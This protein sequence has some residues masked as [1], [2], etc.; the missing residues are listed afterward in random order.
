M[1]LQFVLQRQQSH[2][3]RATP[4]SVLTADIFDPF[5]NWRIDLKNIATMTGGTM[6]YI[7]SQKS[8]SLTI[9]SLLSMRTRLTGLC[10]RMLLYSGVTA[11][12]CSP[13][14]TNFSKSSQEKFFGTALP[15]RFL[16]SRSQDLR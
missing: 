12:S 7:R 16:I 8:L 9:S 5:Y 3:V 10:F 6:N 13:S 15:I 11:T 2:T 14:G 4:N 1:N